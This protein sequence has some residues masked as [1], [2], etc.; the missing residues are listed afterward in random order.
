MI[1]LIYQK[2]NSSDMVPLSERN[3]VKSCFLLASTTVQTELYPIGMKIQ[4]LSLLLDN[5]L[6]LSPKKFCDW[7]ILPNLGTSPETFSMCVNQTPKT[8]CIFCYFAKYSI[9]VAVKS[10]LVNK[11][12]Q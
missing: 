12:E 3:I 5:T 10:Q 4:P 2:I 6:L 7:I 8:G 11:L 9:L 1:S